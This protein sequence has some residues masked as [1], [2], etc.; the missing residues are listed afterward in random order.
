MSTGYEPAPIA[1]HN[2]ERTTVMS[3]RLSLIG[4]K[5]G[6]LLVLEDGPIIKVGALA[7]GR[8]TSLCLC[9]CGQAKTIQ[10]SHLI[11]GNTSSCGCVAPEKTILRCT[12]HGHKTRRHTAYTYVSWQNMWK[13]CTDPNHPKYHL[14]GG[15]GIRVC[16]RWR[17]YRNFLTD[18]GERPFGLT[19]DRWP[20]KNGNYE[21]SNCRWATPKQQAQNRRVRSR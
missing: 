15:R 13:R 10:S 6:K 14:W 3:K 7:S 17:D 1:K 12:I 11:S 16:D 4:R 2:N 5:F 20:D 9:D 19:I 21:P 8:T 18:M